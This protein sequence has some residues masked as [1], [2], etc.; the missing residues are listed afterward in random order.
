LLQ[1]GWLLE[2]P[3]HFDRKVIL[4]RRMHGKGS[5]AYGKFIVTRAS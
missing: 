4:E 1:D 3:A 2:K 5:G